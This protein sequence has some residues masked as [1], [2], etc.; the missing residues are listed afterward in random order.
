MIKSYQA[1]ID[2]YRSKFGSSP[3]HQQSA[4]RK[5]KHNVRK[6]KRTQVR[7]NQ[8]SNQHDVMIVHSSFN[9]CI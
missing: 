8:Q 5:R 6:K 3:N 7:V 4:L 1:V 9:H 2:S